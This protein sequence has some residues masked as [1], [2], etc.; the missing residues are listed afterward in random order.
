[1]VARYIHARKTYSGSSDIIRNHNLQQQQNVS[2]NQHF[3]KKTV[4][5]LNTEV[6]LV[7]IFPNLDIKK[8]KSKPNS[9]PITPILF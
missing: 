7:Y 1:M 5:S 9:H 8:K 2:L 4:K 6:L 3:I